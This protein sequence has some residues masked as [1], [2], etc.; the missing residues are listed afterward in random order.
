MFRT[1]NPNG[2][3]GRLEF[4]RSGWAYLDVSTGQRDSGRWR[5]DADSQVCVAW[6]SA[7]EVCALVRQLDEQLWIR[8]RS[9]HVVRL[10]ER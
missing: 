5:T 1:D 8:G 9:G 2:S 4:Q 3:T 10:N 7:G 6:R